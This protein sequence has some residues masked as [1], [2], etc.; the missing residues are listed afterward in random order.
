MRLFLFIAATI[1]F[2][3]CVAK[4]KATTTNTEIAVEKIW[5]EAPHSAFTDLIRFNNNWYCVFRE[6]PGHMSGPVGQARVLKSKD[7]KAWTSVSLFEMPGL[8]IRDP[9]IS[10]APG[11]RLMIL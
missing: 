4:K 7:G 10:I 8:D 5:S 6:A 1:L 2:S 11:N 3:G 9:K